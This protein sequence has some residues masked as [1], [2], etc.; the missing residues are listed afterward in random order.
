VKILITGAFGQDGTILSEQLIQSSHDVIGTYFPGFDDPKKHLFLAP[1]NLVALDVTNQ[2]EVAN[3]L[4]NMSPEVVIHLAGETSVASSWINPARTMFSNVIGTTYFLEWIKNND[5][6]I[7]FINATSVEVFDDNESV[8]SE[9]SPMKAKNP[10]GV[11]KLATA[12]LVSALRADDLLLTNAFL[13]NHESIY[14]PETFVMGKIARGVAAIADGKQET[15]TLGDILITRDWSSAE[16]I[17]RGIKLIVEKKFIGDLILASGCN[18][19]LSQIVELAFTSVGI[20]NW[21]DHVVS[22][23][24][25]LRTNDE[26]VVSYNISSA[27][28][29][30]DWKPTEPTEAW[31]GKMVKHFRES[32]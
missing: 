23:E 27:N 17:C 22:D 3:T 15:L 25:L 6:E 31:I 12:Q 8:I 7:H 4:A 9:S 2:S 32:L 16:D 20:S 28:R 26:R 24:S 14:R 18:H 21:Q 11:S 10:Y 5:P 30:I 29:E 13:S 1:E 19:Q